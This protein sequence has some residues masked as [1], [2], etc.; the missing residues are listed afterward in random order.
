MIL[1]IDISTS[2]IGWCV[3]NENE[4]VLD[5]G[6]LEFDK[7]QKSLYKKLAEFD[8]LLF[9]IKDKY[10]RYFKIFV[11]SPLFGSNNQNVVNLLQRWNGMCCA[12]IYWSFGVEPVLIPN[13]SALKAVG[14]KIPKGTK[15]LE[16][17]KFIFEHTK[18]QGFFPVEKVEY[19]R[20][21]NLKNYIFDMSDAIV[22]ALAGLK[23]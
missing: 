2:V 23:Q 3:I 9:E 18:S 10:G 21:G 4:K 13:V 1:G 12:Q 5:V 15:G 16:R 8:N 14:I 7:K 20:T 6:H 17:K 11:E 22:I 19:K